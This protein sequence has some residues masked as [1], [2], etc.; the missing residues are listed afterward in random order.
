MAGLNYSNGDC[1][2]TLDDD[3]QHLR[4]FFQIYSN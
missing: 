1:V 4:N 3:L 2:I